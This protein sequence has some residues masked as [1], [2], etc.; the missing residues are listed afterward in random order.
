MRK[1]ALLA[2]VAFAAACGDSSSSGGG[3]GYI[4]VA[5]LAPTATPG[6]G[7]VDIDFCV[8][9]SGGTYSAPVMAGALSPEG[10]VYGGTG[11]TIGGKQMT[12][13]FGYAAGTYDIKVKDRAA[14]GNCTTAL[15][16]LT[17]VTLGDGGYKTIA[18]VGGAGSTSAPYALVAFT[19]EVSV[20][21]T[22]VGIRFVN[23]SV[24]PGT[25]VSPGPALDIGISSA[26]VP[27]QVIFPAVAYPAKAAAGGLVDANGYAVL[28]ASTLPTGAL[29]LNICAAGVSPPSPYCGSAGI[30][31]GQITGGI[32][33]SVYVIGE[34]GLSSSALFCGDVLNGSAIQA[35]GNY[36]TCTSALQ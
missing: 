19:D 29:T 28:T 21:T 16:T 36:S 12:K 31:S 3:T 26:T 11:V 15:A 2:V 25:T 7:A 1:I 6:V 4:R 32:I 5:N 24:L 33:A 13:Y 8:A 18:F 9:P 30:P 10:V 14:A 17:G 22:A 34:A 35:A 23:A 20:A 27:N